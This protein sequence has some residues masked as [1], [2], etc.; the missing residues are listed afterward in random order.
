[1][2]RI[3]PD[4]IYRTPGAPL[5]QATTTDDRVYVS[6]QVPRMS[7][8]SMVD[9]SIRAQTVQTL[10]NLQTVLNAAD[11]SMR[12]LLKLTIFVRRMDDLEEIN[13]VYRETIP[14]PYPA[15]SVIEVTSF[16]LENMDIEIEAI[17]ER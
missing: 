12:D 5:S 9:E 16:A 4:D 3:N 7:D 10:T 17:A 11:S 13:G 8:G 15:R 14:E 1:M 6:G 2:S